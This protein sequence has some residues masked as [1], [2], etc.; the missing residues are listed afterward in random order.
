VMSDIDVDELSDLLE[1]MTKHILSVDND[2][3]IKYLRNGIKF[4]ENLHLSRSGGI[5]GIIN[6]LFEK[7][8]YYRYVKIFVAILKYSLIAV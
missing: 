3:L 4:I 7:K 5:T 2:D 6:S 1:K 8:T